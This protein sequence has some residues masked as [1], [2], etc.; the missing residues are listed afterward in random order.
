MSTAPEIFLPYQQRICGDDSRVRVIEKSRRVGISWALAGYSVLEASGA[1]GWNVY[2]MGYEKE[3][4]QQ[5]IKDAADFARALSI[6]VTEVGEYMFDDS[7]D[8][9]RRNGDTRHILAYVI[10]FASGYAIHALS[11]HPR[12]FRSRQGHAIVDEAAFH[13]DLGG[14]LKAALAFL[15]WGRGRVTLVSS[16]NGV[17]NP[18][19]V[20]C[21]DIRKG[22]KKYKLHTIKFDEAC[23]EGLYDRVCLRDGKESTPEGFDEWYTQTVDDYGEYADE[24]LFCI[25]RASGGS[26]IPHHLI[27]P[28]MYDAPVVQLTM[29]DAF[30]KRPEP[31][32]KVEIANWLDTIVRP[33]LNTL[34][35]DEIHVVGEDFGRKSDLT[36]IA[37]LAINKKLVRRCPFLIELRN[38]PYKQQEQIV[39]Y[40]IDGLPRFSKGAFDD[41][42]N[43]NYLAEQAKERYGESIIEPVYMG[44]KWYA[45]NLP[46]FKAA[47]EDKTIMVPRD[48]DVLSDLQMFKTIKGTPKLPDVRLAEIKVDEKQ[49]KRHMRHGDAGIALALA[50]YASRRELKYE[51]QGVPR[52]QADSAPNER[53]LRLTQGIKASKGGML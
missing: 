23:R 10:R 35:K 19:N 44:E 18:F 37:P 1:N 11:S 3:M 7:S 51:Y 53:Q 6:A 46:P 49:G 20:L 4:T 36:V 28:Q 15:I 38:I 25:P 22:R 40:V 30:G 27:E 13:P 29:D 12:N 34:S 52:N 32:R 48:A 31:S 26:Y 14:I 24:E 43:G 42:G 5:F 45:E 9:E 47:F 17:E 41:G 2:Y 16:H 39:F 8:T 21:E 33:I 50:H